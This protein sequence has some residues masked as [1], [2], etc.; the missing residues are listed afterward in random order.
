[1]YWRAYLKQP[2][3]TKPKLIGQFDIAAPF[4]AIE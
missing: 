1:M 4:G 3:P 2:L